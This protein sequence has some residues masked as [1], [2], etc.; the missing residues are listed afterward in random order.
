[1]FMINVNNEDN[2]FTCREGYELKEAG[3]VGVEAGERTI[4]GV[5]IISGT[6]FFF[7]SD[8][9]SITP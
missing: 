7:D 5:S 3:V 8:F 4:S 2:V 9:P 1:M 6:N